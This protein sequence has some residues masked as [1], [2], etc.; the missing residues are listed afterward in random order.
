[1]DDEEKQ[2]V[3]DP[4][5]FLD[6]DAALEYTQ[7]IRKRLVEDIVSAGMPTAEDNRKILLQTL[8]DIDSNALGKKKIKADEKATQGLQ[9]MSSLV[10]EMLTK[11]ATSGTGISVDRE[12]PVLGADVPDPILVP[13]ETGGNDGGLDYDAIM[14]RS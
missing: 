14:N 8:K 10:A 2:I 5:G 13:G 7:G 6:D 11:V 3:S 4:G 12:L 9:G 1:M